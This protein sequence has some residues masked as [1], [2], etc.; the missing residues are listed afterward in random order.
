MPQ[1]F[2]IEPAFLFYFATATAI[3]LLAARTIVRRC[4]NLRILP[5]GT[6]EEAGH[7]VSLGV[8]AACA[9]R[10]IDVIIHAPSS[11]AAVLSLIGFAMMISAIRILSYVADAWS[12]P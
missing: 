7:Y 8:V 2:S 5:F 4:F 10:V 1:M 6:I 11:N 9:V 3:T 12:R